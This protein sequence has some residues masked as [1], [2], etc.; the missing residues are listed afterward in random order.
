MS[1]FG[2]NISCIGHAGNIDPDINWYYKVNIVSG[3]SKLDMILA[4]YI[5]SA[6]IWNHDFDFI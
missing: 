5:E 3:T 4:I 6:D 1:D 2:I